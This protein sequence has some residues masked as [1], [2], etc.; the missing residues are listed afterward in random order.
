MNIN[1]Y[2]KQQHFIYRPWVAP[3]FARLLNIKYRFLYI[4]L[5]I[6]SVDTEMSDPKPL[7]ILHIFN[8]KKKKSWTQGPGFF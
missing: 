6:T 2:K 5:D 7:S 8:F 3:L 4:I 1:I